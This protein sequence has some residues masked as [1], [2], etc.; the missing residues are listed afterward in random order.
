MIG[1]SIVTSF[2]SLLWASSIA[3]TPFPSSVMVASSS[4]REVENTMGWPPWPL[5]RGD[6][7]VALAARCAS[8]IVDTIWGGRGWSIAK[9]TMSVAVD[10]TEL[11]PALIDVVLPRA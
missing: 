10:L 4:L 1:S 5:Y 3:R 6:V 11:R 7:I 9:R 2:T 8:T